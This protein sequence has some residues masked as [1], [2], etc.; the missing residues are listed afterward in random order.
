MFVRCS[1]GVVYS[2]NLITSLIALALL[3]VVVTTAFLLQTYYPNPIAEQIRE[4]SQFFEDRGA[5]I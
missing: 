2:R 5:L 1:R 3:I 4:Q